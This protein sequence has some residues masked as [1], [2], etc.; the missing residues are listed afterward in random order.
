MKSTDV[1]EKEFWRL[2]LVTAAWL[3]AFLGLGIIIWRIQVRDAAKYQNRR[4]KQCV[5]RVRLPGV[6]GMIF[7]RN[8]VALAQN[9][10]SYCLVVY[11]EELRRPGKW[12]NTIDQVEA[13]LDRLA[14]VIG[15]PRGVSREAIRNHIRRRLPLP[16]VAWRDLAEE[17]VAR[18][19]AHAQEFPGVDLM[20]EPLRHYP[21]GTVAAHVVGYV[22]RGAL[23]EKEEKE[24]DF[25]LP[26]MQGKCGVERAFDVEL[27]GRP[28]AS[29]I[30]V[31]A[32]GFKHE[33]IERRNPKNG[34]DLYLTIDVRIQ[35]IVAAALQGT[36]GA[37]V[38][39]DP[40]NGEVLALV[41]TPAFDPNELSLGISPEQWR[42]LATNAD[43]PLFNRALSGTYPPG[44]TFKPLIAIAAMENH[45]ATAETTFTCQGTFE[46]G[47][48]TLACWQPVG[49]GTI[50]LRKALEQS[51]NSYFFQLAL[52]TNYE[53]IY[54]M[55]EALGF[56]RKTG[57]GLL[58]EKAGLLPDEKWKMRKL[59]EPW[60]AGD[61]CN[62]AI[63]Q[64]FLLATPIQMALFCA[65]I[66]NGGHV[67]RPHIVLHPRQ[68]AE[69]VNE[70]CWSSETIA[71]VQGGMYDAV[72]A[73]TGTGK[74]ARAERMAVAGK[75][76]SA[77][78]GSRAQS[79][80]YAWMIAFAPFEHPCYALALVIEQ[81]TAGG[82]DAAPRIRFIMERLADLSGHSRLAARVG[83]S[84]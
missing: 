29:L 16:L 57:I 50:A 47:D 6:R 49:H 35:E 2:R 79:L 8:G 56:G 40:R 69:I 65:T 70:M 34:A 68:D 20:V 30:R 1:Q 19:A 51:C 5:R 61:T 44:S 75:T 60:R 43:Q 7:D 83:R 25:Y 58:E 4:D 81:A 72:N 80:K 36:N 15:L 67:Y 62:L 23:N 74:R 9:R 48:Q 31:D 10:L 22:G 41:S 64:G 66:A 53:R 18:W 54:H 63:G 77:E 14:K 26:E 24:V 73:E 78:Y 76:G 52:L 17:A 27:A 46:I 33:E 39:L 42:A 13:S 82:V 28:G 45:K 59:G 71:V 32:S 84:G 21:K 11:V 12:D 55:A 37:A 38:V 3:V